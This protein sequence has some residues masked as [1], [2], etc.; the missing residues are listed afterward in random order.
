MADISQITIGSTTYDLKDATARTSISG[1]QD[2]LTVGNGIDIT[3]DVISNTQ[4]IEYIVG[5]QTAATNAW[6]GVSTDSSLSTGKIIAYKLPYAGT[7]YAATLQLTMA[8]GTTTSAIELRRAGAGSVTTHFAVNNVIIMV[9]DGTYWRVSAYYDTNNNTVPTG[10]CTTGASTA[11]KKATCTDGYRDDANYFP[12]LFKYANTAA[13]AKLAISSY[14]ETALPI[15]VNGARTSSS[16][17]FGRGVVMF[18][19]YN[20]AYYCYNDGRFPI[21]VNGTVTSVQ[22]QLA[23]YT[24][25]ASLATVATS[26]SYNDLSD[27]P[28]IAALPTVTSSDNGKFL[29]VVNGAWAAETVPS[30]NGVNF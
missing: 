8:D 22:D 16:N 10:Y 28:T 23:L 3:S 25:T 7:S 12:C 27:K 2:V 18:L 5:T 14:A 29:R 9:Y 15:Y 4:G 13:N 24:P 21:V 1:K 11:A 19:Y 30:A 17:T 20:S 6:T 26:G